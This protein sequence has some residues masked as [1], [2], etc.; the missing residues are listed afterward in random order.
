MITSFKTK[1][2][3]AILISTIVAVCAVGSMS[4]I[5]AN[6]ILREKS[7]ATLQLTCE[8][9]GMKMNQVISGIR[10]SVDILNKRA[11][12]SGIDMKQ[13]RS[14][15]AYVR[16][17]TD[18]MASIVRTMAESTPGCLAVYIRYNP[19]IASPTSG[20]FL[21][22]TP[23]QRQFVQQPPTDL[24]LYAKTDKEHVGWFYEAVEAR[25]PVWMLPYENKNIST[26]MVSYVAPLE[27]GGQNIG[28]VGM[29][30]DY[31]YI[32]NMVQDI[33]VYSSGYAFLTYGN[34]VMEHHSYPAYTQISDVL[35][36][37]SQIYRTIM[38]TQSRRGEYIYEG[39][40][41]SFAWTQ[42]D[43]GMR[44]FICA[45]TSEIYEDSRNLTI[46]IILV[47]I[48]LLLVIVSIS[49]YT[50]NH[51]MKLAN[52][53]ELTGIGN[54]KY[55]L[56][57]FRNR[58]LL[59]DSYYSLFLLDIDHFKQVN[60]Q[61]GHNNGDLALCDLAEA[62]RTVLGRDAL[63]ARWG[64][65]EF[66]GALESEN[67]ERRLQ[68]LLAY[69]R[70]LQDRPY[71]PITISIGLQQIKPDMNFMDITKG[72]DAALYQSKAEGRDRLTIYT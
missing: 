32:Q 56:Q 64:G 71:G 61:Y 69:V 5:T 16:E 24:S 65:D 44:L 28:I 70:K 68:E 19:E 67:A 46:E 20:L 26:Y 23:E 22:W 55:F 1:M 3:A 47:S 52:N 11:L 72:A 38:E 36:E 8:Q 57:S 33:S 66:I 49:N 48:L 41:K 60:D 37:D 54:R 4:I 63:F 14:S 10:W 58:Q 17:Y 35:G 34:M 29:D 39:K 45:P 62:L 7:E 9:T 40:K 59:G 21:V 42:L 51:M 30:I 2:I 25:H 50:I 12:N 13:F 27:V 31:S 53:D 18:R 43:N 6:K 15:D